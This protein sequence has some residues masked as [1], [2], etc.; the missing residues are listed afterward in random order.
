MTANAV[1]ITGS[2]A[3]DRIDTPTGSRTDIL[4]GSATYALVAAGRSCPVHLVGVVGD[5]FPAEGLDLFRRYAADLSDLQIKSGPTF[6]WGGRYRANWDDRETL[7]TELGVFG[8]FAPRLSA[9][10]RG[11]GYLYMANIHPALQEAVIDQSPGRKLVVVDT[12][13]LWIKTTPGELRRVLKKAQILL[14]NASEARELTGRRNLAPAVADLQALGP[15]VVVIKRGT[16]GALLFDGDGATQVGA[17]PV[18]EVVDPTGAGDTF[19]GGLIAALASG[20][21]LNEALVAASALASVCVEGFGIEALQG[22]SR[23]ELEGRRAELRA[24]LRPWK[25][26]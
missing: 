25:G 13:N 15:G 18:P 17:Y 1:L 23:S 16:R 3:L 6:R 26:L 22:V 7:Y 8:S 2:I 19:G 10:N 14:V 24:T 5:D 12:M 11:L 20:E 9:S 21:G 4:G